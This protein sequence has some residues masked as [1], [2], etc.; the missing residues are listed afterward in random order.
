MR[1]A[2][3]RVL[4]IE[5]LGE[6]GDDDHAIREPFA[7]GVIFDLER[8][9]APCPLLPPEVGRRMCGVQEAGDPRDIA[10]QLDVT[11]DDFGVHVSVQHHRG[12][13]TEHII[14]VS[15]EEGDL[16]VQAPTAL[17]VVG[18]FPEGSCQP[19]RPVSA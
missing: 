11:V 8:G 4:S 6:L 3:A 14:G 12:P 1:R 2:S 5:L 7:A 18:N 13:L 16:V 19:R 9:A 10:S 17:R 15:G